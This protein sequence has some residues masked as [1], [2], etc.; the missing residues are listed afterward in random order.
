MT[1]NKPKIQG[2]ISKEVYEKFEVWYK[3]R[4]IKNVSTA[5]EILLRD[6]FDIEANT[7]VSRIE[8]LELKFEALER[9]STSELKVDNQIESTNDVLVD[10]QSTNNLEVDTQIKS[11]NEALV[12]NTDGFNRFKDYID[13]TSSDLAKLYSLTANQFKKKS[14]AGWFI[15]KGWTI[16]QLGRKY[17]YS[18]KSDKV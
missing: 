5:L 6:Y 4:N 2:Y 10:N 15:E 18:R 11:T 13:L 12:D 7:L 9:Q 8:R 14:S 1:T 17:F 16:R 3:E